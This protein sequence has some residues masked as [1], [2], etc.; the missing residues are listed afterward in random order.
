MNTKRGSAC[1]LTCNVSPFLKFT[2]FQRGDRFAAMQIV[3]RRISRLS[4]PL[5]VFASPWVANPRKDIHR[6]QTAA[7]RSL[8]WCGYP[9]LI[10][11]TVY[12][13]VPFIVSFHDLRLVLEPSCDGTLARRG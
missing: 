12:G 9:R 13:L 2:T 4:L 1:T 6:S 11:L 7:K 3:V 5:G 8:E 10:V